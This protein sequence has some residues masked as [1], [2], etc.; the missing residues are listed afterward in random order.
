[1]TKLAERLLAIAQDS[2][3][4]NNPGDLFSISTRPRRPCYV[5]LRLY[6]RKPPRFEESTTIPTFLEWE[7]PCVCRVPQAVVEGTGHRNGRG[8]LHFARPLIAAL[9]SE[10]G[11]A[12]VIVQTSD[13]FDSGDRDDRT[14]LDVFPVEIMETDPFL[15]SHGSI[16]SKRFFHRRGSTLVETTVANEFPCALSRQSSLVT[17]EIVSTRAPAAP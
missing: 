2:P 11:A 14:C 13:E 12:N 15:T 4:S 6:G 17:T 5:V 9:E 7:K 3:S 8:V 16:L 10:C 1:M